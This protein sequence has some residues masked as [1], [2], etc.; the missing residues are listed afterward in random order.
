MSAEKRKPLPPGSVFKLPGHS[1]ALADWVSMFKPED[2]IWTRGNCALVRSGEGRRLES[3]PPEGEEEVCAWT[4]ERYREEAN[5]FMT[6]DLEL[7]VKMIA[8][9]RHGKKGAGLLAEKAADLVDCLFTLAEDGNQTAASRLAELLRKSVHRLTALAKS[10]AAV[11]RPVARKSWKWPVMKSRHP[12]LSDEHEEFLGNLNLGYD[13]PFH[14]DRSSHWRLDDK[15]QIALALLFYVWGARKEQR[16]ACDYGLV[17]R[18]AD[19]L[20]DFRKGLNAEKWWELAEAALLWT[21]PKPET[22]PELADLVSLKRRTPSVVREKI[23]ERLKQRFINFA[24][25]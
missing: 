11:L 25:P 23:L 3:N 9:A 4:D 24:K 8:R 7:Q 13:L 5:R 1:I 16:G 19:K 22:I 12:L 14:F 20:P 18:F 2:V 6:A 10:N 17:G 21:Y 15:A